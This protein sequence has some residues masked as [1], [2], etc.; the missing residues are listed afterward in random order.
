MICPNCHSQTETYG[1]WNGG[2]ITNQ[3]IIEKIHGGFNNHQICLDLGINPSKR[4]YER[5]N[6]LRP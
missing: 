6:K 4:S 1:G 5:I 3:Q 2:K